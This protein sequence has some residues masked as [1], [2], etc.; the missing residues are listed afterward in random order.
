M[1]A[2]ARARAAATTVMVDIDYRPD[3]WVDRTTFASA[4]QS[5][6]RHAHIALGTEEEMTAALD[7]T[8]PLDR[9]AAALRET[10]P[11]TVVVKRGKAGS[12]I[13]TASDARVDVPPFDVDVLN[14]L[15]ADGRIV[16]GRPRGSWISSQYRW[17]T[18]DNWLPGGLTPWPA[19]AA[20]TELARQWLRAFGPAP[21]SDL[22]W[23]AGWTAGNLKQALSGLDVVEVDL[24]GG[25]GLLLADDTD[26]VPDRP[27]WVALLPALDPTV[28]GW[29]DRGWFLGPHAA[30]L[31]DRTGNAGPT[32][33]YSGR[34]VGGWAQSASGEVRYRLLEDVGREVDGMV[35]RAAAELT[36]WLGPVRVTPRF[37]TPLERE[38]AG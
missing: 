9:I 19:A 31:F 11:E 13:Y 16:R 30:A 15:G 32:V 34:V 7:R 23:W 33:W 25:T 10:G 37:R 24:D 27:P 1:Y 36:A 38:L 29:V 8:G 17:S 20:R 26:E 14:V 6:L 18:I 35:G 28:M 3:Q 12:R 5:L 22:R 2:A 4:M 21:A